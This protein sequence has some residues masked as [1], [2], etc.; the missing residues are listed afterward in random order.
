MTQQANPTDATVE[1]CVQCAFMSWDARREEF[2][3]AR[4]PD[5]TKVS[6]L[7]SVCSHGVKATRRHKSQPPGNTQLTLDLS[8]PGIPRE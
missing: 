4:T 1:C 7:R 3:C 5:R 2:V 8:S 6:P